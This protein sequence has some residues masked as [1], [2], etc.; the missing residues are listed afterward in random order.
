LT[1]VELVKW[2][3]SRGCEKWWIVFTK[4][5]S[6]NTSGE[7]NHV[8]RKYDRGGK[9]KGNP[10]VRK[11]G[12]KKT[13]CQLE[14]HGT[15]NHPYDAHLEGHA[16]AMRLSQNEL[17]L[18]NQL[19]K[20]NVHPKDIL[21]RHRDQKLD[22]VAG[23]KTVYNARA[24]LKSSRRVGETPMQVNFSVLQAHNCIYTSLVDEATNT[25]EGVFFIHL[26]SYAI[27]C[28]YHHVLMI[29]TT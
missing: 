14:L 29:D 22:N 6:A 24:K 20:Q 23:L 19:I 27:W 2:A 18:V 28:V 9:Y 4:R 1:R 13:N 25:E 17:G 10:K 7:T 3:S 26:A 21:G 5:S 15:H 16:Y 8:W 12:T 11:I